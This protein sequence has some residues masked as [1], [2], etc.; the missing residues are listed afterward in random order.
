MSEIQLTT[1]VA[2]IFMSSGEKLKP[3]D[4]AE[5]ARDLVRAMSLALTHSGDDIIRTLAEDDF[6]SAR[7]ETMETRKTYFDEEVPA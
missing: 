2:A 1:L 5:K 4:A 6:K 7:T 3:E